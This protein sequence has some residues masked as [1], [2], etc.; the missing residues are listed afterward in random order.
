MSLKH[1]AHLPLKSD[2]CFLFRQQIDEDI[3]ANVIALGFDRMQ[4]EE[5]LRNRHQNKVFVLLVSCSGNQQ[6]MFDK[7][8]CLA[9]LACEKVAFTYAALQD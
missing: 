7:L 5:S 6:A 4:L 8:C 2:N 1:C 9:N 3:L